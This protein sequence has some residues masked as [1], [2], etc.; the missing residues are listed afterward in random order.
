LRDLADTL[1]GDNIDRKIPKEIGV[2]AASD[3]DEQ[4]ANKEPENLRVATPNQKWQKTNNEHDT[5]KGKTF[6][7]SQ[8]MSSKNE[9]NDFPLALSV[10][11]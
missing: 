4:H 3:S 8:Q 6:F 1:I 7:C 5:E 9:L 10:K 11:N 2:K